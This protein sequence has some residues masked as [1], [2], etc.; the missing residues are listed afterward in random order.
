[1]FW[2]SA[3]SV[4]AAD[5]LAK[6][7]VFRSTA[8]SHEYRVVPGIVFRIAPVVNTGV[9]WGLLGKWPQVVLILGLCAAALVLY[10]FYRHSANSRLEACVMGMLLGAAA[11]NM[12]DRLLAGHVRDYLDFTLF[13]F[14]WPTF[15]LADTF[16]CLGAGILLILLI[17]GGREKPQKA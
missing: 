3:V 8:P 14:S 11:G 4:F 15:N 13:G 2:M 17:M 7:L 5:Q 16:L 1:L 6:W 10:Y 9:A 12:T